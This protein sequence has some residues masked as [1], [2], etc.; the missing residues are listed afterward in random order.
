MPILDYAQ[1]S[2]LS[3]S[4]EAVAHRDAVTSA[5]IDAIARGA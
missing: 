4:A 1:A 2:T 5:A 3:L